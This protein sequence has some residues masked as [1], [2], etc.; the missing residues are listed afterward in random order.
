MIAYLDAN[1]VIYLIEIAAVWGPKAAARIGRLR[2]A[3]DEVAVSDIARLEC[4]VGPLTT[5]DAVLVADFDAFF[6]NP[7]VLVLPVTAADCERAARIRA[8]YRFQALDALHL[9]AAVEH[10]CGMFLT[11]DAALAGF[12]DV[13]VEIL[14]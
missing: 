7:G 9:A 13:P 2:A 8:V 12:P 3:G 5:G 6:R 14:K 10:G 1:V 11:N 4:L